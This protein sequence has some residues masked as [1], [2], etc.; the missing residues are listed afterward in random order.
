M[1]SNNVYF[2]FLKS[3]FKILI[4]YLIKLLKKTHQIPLYFYFFNF[5]NII[6]KPNIFDFIK[7]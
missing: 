7:H 3:D 1:I 2:Y 5:I 6:I 4:Y